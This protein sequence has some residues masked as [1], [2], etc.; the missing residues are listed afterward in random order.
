VLNEKGRVIGVTLAES[1]RRGRIYAATPR[2]I[3]EFL[4]AE[5]IQA[6]GDPGPNM[7]RENY[8]QRAD[9]LRRNLTVAQAV[10]VPRDAPV[11]PG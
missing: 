1:A 7:T 8:G 4:Q 5:K 11:N 2:S 10:C 6:S 9:Q 3:T